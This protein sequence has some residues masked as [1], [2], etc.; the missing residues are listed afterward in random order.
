MKL[1]LKIPINLDGVLHLR[2]GVHEIDDKY[3]DHWF[4]NAL[5]KDKNAEFSDTVKQEKVAPPKATKG[6][7]I[8]KD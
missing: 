7:S 4:L 6:K 1:T 8:A 2:P 3:Q 5:K